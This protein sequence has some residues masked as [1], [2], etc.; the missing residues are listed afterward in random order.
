MPAIVCSTN[1]TDD[2]GDINSQT[3]DF[4]IEDNKLTEINASVKIT[5]ANGN[6]IGTSSQ[7]M[8]IDKLMQD[9]G[10]GS[11]FVGNDG[12][13]FVDEKVLSEEFEKV[14]NSN[15]GGAYEYDCVVN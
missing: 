13:L 9:R 15:A 4:M 8:S 5:D 10:D 11:E 12:T 2:S 14:L 3:I 6:E 7:V 1:Y